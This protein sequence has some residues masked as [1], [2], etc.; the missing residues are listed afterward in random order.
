[1]WIVGLLSLGPLFARGVAETSAAAGRYTADTR[2]VQDATIY[3][4]GNVAADRAIVIA[5]D[6]ATSYGYEAT[7]ALPAY[8]QDAGSRSRTY[9]WP[10]LDPARRSPLHEAVAETTAAAFAYPKALTSSDVGGIVVAT[11]PT[12][13]VTLP[14]WF[15]SVPWR[16]VSF[17]RAYYALVLAKLRY[18]RQGHVTYRVL[19]HGEEASFTPADHPLVVVA[20]PLRGQVG[21]NPFLMTP[22]WGV[23]KEGS[24]SVLWLGDGREGV[25]TSLLWSAREQ[26]VQIACDV[27][28]GPGREDL[29]RTVELSLAHAAGMHVDRQAFDGSAVLMFSGRL[30]RGRNK[31]TLK[32][33]DQATIRQRPNGDPRPLLVVVR[34]ITV[35]SPSD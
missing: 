10:V 5:A 23:E 8:L 14:S 26:A 25:M 24:G 18:V 3:L 34:R 9:L 15:E 7:Y 20:P 31:L 1:M 11:P 21:V 29:R 32:V 12:D 6:P 13:L 16:E 19:V 28:A 22:W 35:L 4:A 17:S 2:A 30:H 27:V 33:L